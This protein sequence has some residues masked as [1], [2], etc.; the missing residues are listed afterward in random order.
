MDQIKRFE[1][2]VR[3]YK[4]YAAAALFVLWGVLGFLCGSVD[5]HAAVESIAAGLGL[6]GIGHK[7]D[8]GLVPPVYIYSGP[9]VELESIDPLSRT[10]PLFPPKPQETSPPPDAVC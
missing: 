1:A 3:G 2:A 4:T 10:V 9:G 5:G 8:R 7:L 6:L